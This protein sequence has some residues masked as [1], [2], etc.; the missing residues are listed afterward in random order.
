MNYIM[1]KLI[2]LLKL[3]ILT[4]KY[5]A[6]KSTKGHYRGNHTFNNFKRRVISTGQADAM[7]GPL[8]LHYLL[9]VSFVV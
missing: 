7:V 5:A 9:R 3:N 4:V 8:P 6:D 2:A 1:F